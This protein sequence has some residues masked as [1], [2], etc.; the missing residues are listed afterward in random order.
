M[1]PDET[2]SYAAALSVSGKA[3]FYLILAPYYLKVRARTMHAESWVPGRCCTE[4]PCFFL[5][6]QQTTCHARSL[7]WHG[8]AW[9]AC[10]SACRWTPGLP[11]PWRWWCA[12]HVWPMLPLANCKQ[13]WLLRSHADASYT[14]S[15]LAGTQWHDYRQALAKS[16]D[17][18]EPR[19]A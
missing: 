18:W 5:P 3:S 14:V 11:C 10:M 13:R 12:V 19:P 4:S 8:M 2:C 6:Q 9:H 1:S 15:V 17:G 7:A 16:S